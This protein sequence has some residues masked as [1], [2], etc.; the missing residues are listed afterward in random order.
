MVLRCWCGKEFS[1]EGGDIVA[2]WTAAQAAGW[3][4]VAEGN[5]VTGHPTQWACSVEHRQALRSV[6]PKEPA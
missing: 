2:G 1:F 6:D 3:K 5:V 4:P